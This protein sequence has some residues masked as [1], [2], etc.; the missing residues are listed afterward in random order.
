MVQ[1]LSGP[2]GRAEGSPP[3]RQRLRAC[4]FDHLSQSR[5]VVGKE[6]RNVD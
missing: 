2:A 3:I 5:V 1:H 4:L 6:E